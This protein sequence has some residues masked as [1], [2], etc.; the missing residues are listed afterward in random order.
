LDE[1]AR[2]ELHV[3]VVDVEMLGKEEENLDE[4]RLVPEP[5]MQLTGWEP[6]SFQATY[7]GHDAHR[8]G[9]DEQDGVRA[10]GEYCSTSAGT[11]FQNIS[12]DFR[13][14]CL[15]ALQV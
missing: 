9:D 11:I 13:H 12:G 2:C 6:D 4:S 7:V 8:V 10:S 3:L 5:M 1:D 15:W 14:R